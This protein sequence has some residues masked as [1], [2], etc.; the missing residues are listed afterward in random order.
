[1]IIRNE[2]FLLCSV[3]MFLDISFIVLMFR[4]EFVL[5]RMY[6]LGFSIVICRIL[7]CFFLLFEKLMFIGCF[8]ILVLIF[9]VFVL[10]WM[11]LRKLL[12]DS[13]F[14]LWVL[15]WVFMVVCRKV[16]LLMFGILIGYWNVRNRLVVVCFFGF[17]FSSF[18][19][20]RV[21]LFLVIL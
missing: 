10:V 14:L 1:M 5:L 11:I 8:S 2:C 18:L 6:I 9:R 19:L 16:M 21:V 7:L 4:F 17:S 20:L 15:C 12:V 3:F 13:F